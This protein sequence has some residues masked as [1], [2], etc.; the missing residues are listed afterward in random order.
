MDEF[1]VIL[2]QCFDFI[3]PFLEI[4]LLTVV[5]YNCLYFLRGTRG[6]HILTGITIILIVLTI[7]SDQLEFEVIS[8]LFS[9]VWAIIPIAMIVIFQPELRRA[10]AQLGT[11]PFTSRKQKKQEALHEV[12]QAVT[13]MSRQNIGALIIF[14]REIGMRSI[15]N[16]AIRINGVLS[17]QL[18]ETIFYPNCPLHDGAV[19]IKEDRVIAA[20]AILPLSQDESLV[21]TLGTRHRAAIGISEETDAVAL[22]VSEETGTI[23]IACRGRIR[24]D[25]KPDKLQRFLQGLLLSEG[26]GG[27]RDIFSSFQDT[28]GFTSLKGEEPVK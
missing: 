20:H 11:A 16:S 23:S 26:D 6:S 24:R 3:R 15:V 4:G 2:I 8:W 25:V 28:E 14:E 5:I 12:V 10:F 7:L 21:R 27:L 9:N 1:I 19:I 13:N 18:L 22:I 17:R